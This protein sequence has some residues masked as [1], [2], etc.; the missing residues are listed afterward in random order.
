MSAYAQNI[1]LLAS[2]E[3]DTNIFQLLLRSKYTMSMLRMEPRATLS[4]SPTH[5]IGF[6]YGPLCLNTS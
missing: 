6:R 5:V 1:L 2:K 4:Y 3:I